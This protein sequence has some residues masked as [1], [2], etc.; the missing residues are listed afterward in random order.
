MLVTTS[1]VNKDL[2]LLQM[3]QKIAEE[4]KDAQKPQQTYSVIALSGEVEG[5]ASISNGFD[6]KTTSD[7]D[8]KAAELDVA[9]LV[10]PWLMGYVT[11]E[12]DNSALPSAIEGYGRRSKGS[13]VQVGQ[14][15]L[16]IGNL[17]RTPV[18][19]TLG[20][21]Y[22]P[23]GQ[24]SSFMYSDSLPKILGRAKIRG[25]VLGYNGM[26]MQQ[27]TGP[28]ATV[29][30]FSGDSRI[31]RK[32]NI[33]E[34][35][36]NLG[37][38]YRQGL[39]KANASVSIIS[40]MADSNGMQSNGV[41]DS[42]QFRGF[43]AN[44]TTEQ[45]QHRV[46]GIDTQ[47][48]LNYGAFTLIGDYLTAMRSF[49]VSD[50][51]YNGSGATPSAMH[52]EGAYNFIFHNRPGSFALGYDHSWQALAFNIPRDRVITALNYSVWRNTIASLEYR[53]DINYNSADRAS[54]TGG[55]VALA[56]GGRT[57][58]NVILV[59]DYFF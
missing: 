38:R 14:G 30:T 34:G 13:N 40:N 33:D 15:F 59:L 16:T 55:S 47:A 35:G 19:F 25:A 58:N 37:Y 36:F 26:G 51:S 45:L 3:K 8:L 32:R 31:T 18:Y 10:H 52:V 12:Y 44:S 23:F 1:S 46:P 50:V 29:Y 57:S 24:Y 43:G 42:D 9:A 21:L 20:Q 28:Y 22:A 53:Y 5:A 49:D 48:N 27:Q 6:N 56:P 11:F 41:G 39:F 17:N 54:G 4:L 2:V 7:L